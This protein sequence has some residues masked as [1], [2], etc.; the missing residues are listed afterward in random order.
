MDPQPTMAVPYDY[1]FASDVPVPLGSTHAS[2]LGSMQV[3]LARGD[4]GNAAD[5]GMLQIRRSGGAWYNV[6]IS[7]A[8]T[9]MGS[10]PPQSLYNRATYDGLVNLADLPGGSTVPSLVDVRLAVFPLYTHPPANDVTLNSVCW[11]TLQV[12]F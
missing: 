11:G 9:I 12:T 4:T 2:L 7:Y 5:I 1:I 6:S 3:N 8:Y 10:N